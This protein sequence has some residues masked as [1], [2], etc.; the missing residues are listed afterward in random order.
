[1]ID[2][3]DESLKLTSALYGSTPGGGEGN[4]VRHNSC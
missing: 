4:S 3:A 1:V 2:V